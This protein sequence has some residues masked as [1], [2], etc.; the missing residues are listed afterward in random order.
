MRKPGTK[1]LTY[2][3]R[4]QIETLMRTS[5]HKTEIAKTVGIGLSTLYREL[6][7]GAYQHT[8]YDYTTETRYSAY[9]AEERYRLLCTAKGRPLKVGKD[10]AFMQYVEKRVVED[11][12]SLGAVAGEIKR[13]KLFGITLSKTTLYRYVELGLFEKL[14]LK[15]ITKKPKTYRKVAK[16]G[17]KGT[18]IEKRPLEIA[19]R[20]TFGHWEM[21]CLCGPTLNT[22]LVLT[23][24]LTRKEIIFPMAR[25]TAGNV[26][27]CLDALE[28]S[29]GEKFSQVFK[30][31]TM[32]NGSEFSDVAGIERSLFTGKRTT[33]Y[34]C[35]PYCSS[36]RGTNERLNRE[37]RRLVPKGTDLGKYTVAD[38]KK[39]ER[40]VNAY[41]RQVL[42]F[43]TSEEL[44]SQQLCCLA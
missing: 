21:D 27:A 5:M 36:E 35:H 19:K 44:F 2:N 7:H 43:A 12:L 25:Q 18:S 3:Q 42:G 38:V 16:S 29:Y 15:H 20:Q 8:K 28:S 13:K 11:K 14:S 40:W 32:D 22:F 30:S 31:I 37:I 41:P 10:F 4:L 6:K 39:I 9:I 1:N 33:T 23:E 24:R 34:Y 26:V 17:P